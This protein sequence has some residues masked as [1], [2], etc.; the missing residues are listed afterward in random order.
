M[1]SVAEQQLRIAAG[2]AWN[3]RW[4]FA[5][6]MNGDGLVTISDAWLWLKWI[7]FAPGDLLLLLLM[8]HGTSVAL[9]FEINPASLYGALSGMFSVFIWLWVIVLYRAG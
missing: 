2:L 1:E 5:A 7:F 4:S 9:F 3:V 6:D 8:S